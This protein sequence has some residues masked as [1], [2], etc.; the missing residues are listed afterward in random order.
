MVDFEFQE[1]G[2]DIHSESYQLLIENAKTLEGVIVNQGYEYLYGLKILRDMIASVVLEQFESSVFDQMLTA[3]S[4]SG[5]VPA[6]LSMVIKKVLIA[7][8]HPTM[9]NN[10]NLDGFGILAGLN[11]EYFILSDL[12]TIK[13]VKQVFDASIPDK[14][15]IKMEESLQAAG[16][17]LINGLKISRFA[18]F[19]NREIMDICRL[20]DTQLVSLVEQFDLQ[21][22]ETKIQKWKRDGLI[23]PDEQVLLTTESENRSNNGGNH[24]GG[25]RSK[26]NSKCRYC[27]KKGHYQRD[28]PK[29]RSDHPIEEV[30]L[31]EFNAS[32][33][34]TSCSARPPFI[35][36]SAAT[37]HV[38]SSNHQLQNLRPTK[39][40]IKGFTGQTD[41]TQ[42]G[43]L[44]LTDHVVLKGVKVVP[45]AAYNVISVGTLAS[46]DLITTFK[47]E[48]GTITKEDGSL[49]AKIVRNNKFW[50]LDEVV[51]QE[52]DAVT[53]ER[54][55]VMSEEKLKEAKVKAHLLHT[56]WGHC[57]GAQLFHLA[58]KQQLSL[59]SA[60][61]QAVIS[62]CLGCKSLVKRPP[63][64]QVDRHYEVGELIQGDL[65]G[66]IFEKYILL[67]S[68]RASKVL[69][70]KIL[71]TKREVSAEFI[72]LVTW[73]QQRIANYH[74]KKVLSIRVD[75]EFRT[76]KMMEFAKRNGIDVQF[77][78]AYASYQNG[79]SERNNR[80][81][82][83]RTR[84]LLD[85]PQVPREYYEYAVNHFIFL[86]NRIWNK[87]LN[88]SPI[89]VLESKVGTSDDKRIQIDGVFGC[90]GFIRPT[91]RNTKKFQLRDIPVIFL[92]YD[93][94]TAIG[95]FLNP[96]DGKI[97]RTD[98][99][100]LV[101]TVY[102]FKNQNPISIEQS[103]PGGGS[104]GH[105]SGSVSSGT[106][107]S[108][109]ADE[110]DDAMGEDIAESKE[111]DGIDDSSNETGSVSRME[112]P[113][114][115]L[116][117][118]SES[119]SETAANIDYPPQSKELMRL[120]NPV[121]V[122]SAHVG[123]QSGSMPPQSILAKPVDPIVSTPGAPRVIMPPVEPQL[124]VPEAYQVEPMYQDQWVT[125]YPGYNYQHDPIELLTVSQ[126][127]RP[128]SSLDPV[129]AI[130][131]KAATGGDDTNSRVR[132]L[133]TE[134]IQL[135]DTEQIS[136]L[137]MLIQQMN[138]DVDV[139]IPQSMAEALQGDES[140][141]WLVAR[142]EELGYMKT[143]DI[144]EEV[145]F[146]DDMDL[147][148]T[149][150]VLSIK[151]TLDGRVIK[152]VRLVARGFQERNLKGENFS[153]VVSLDTLRILLA[154]AAPN[155][156]VIQS[157]D[158]TRAFLQSS[159][160]HP[161]FLVPPEGADTQPGCVWKLNRAIY[162]L[163]TSPADWFNHIRT[164]LL[165]YSGQLQQSVIEQ[166]LFYNPHTK[167]YILLYVDD[168]LILSPN[169]EEVAKIKEYLH[170]EL[171]INE[172]DA[173][174]FIGMDLNYDRTQ[175]RLKLSLES[176]LTGLAAKEEFT[177]PARRFDTPMERGYLGNDL[178]SPLL[179]SGEITKYQQLI[180]VLNYVVNTVRVDVGYSVNYLCQF[181]K[182]PR[183]THWKA[184]Q[185]ILVYLIQHK[186][187]GITYG[188]VQEK[189]KYLK[190]IHQAGEQVAECDYNQ[191]IVIVS[192][193]SYANCPTTRKSTSGF[194]TLYKNQ[195]IDW[196]TGRQPIITLSSCESEYV[197][198]TIAAR[199]CL[200]FKHILMEILPQENCEISLAGD[201]QPGLLMAQNKSLSKLS[202]HIE[203]R[204]HF[205]RNLIDSKTIRLFYI[206][207]RHNLAD[208]LTK[209]LD[210]T[211]FKYLK[212]WLFAD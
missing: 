206:N 119:V 82:L 141:D 131:T 9:V 186:S 79:G 167:I 139:E 90:Q 132:Q 185:R 112:P 57:N 200:F 61:C 72:E 64:H 71:H 17:T 8:I 170:Q 2:G 5:R 80:Y 88:A 198:Y 14:E 45:D 107:S 33:N 168:V 113:S 178:N 184:A 30:N 95:L 156:W 69:K 116:M 54:V 35:I 40:I 48:G 158:A 169:N 196:K 56:Q 106:V 101:P 47:K 108:G 18:K 94:T 70:A 205:I 11:A 147:I 192:D 78:S 36:D 99:F 26:N 179:E 96:E 181:V 194:I 4:Y 140:V 111:G 28:C 189:V 135:V 1:G 27:D 49:I 160:S 44:Q 31:L 176:Y 46:Q 118:T 191:G 73:F 164:I 74:N 159:I 83:E 7:I 127:K 67:V 209:A 207:T 92:G 174:K 183:V 211:R 157:M 136:E 84:K 86:H 77:T 143:H 52:G 21:T 182:S 202:K 137:V 32:S 163:K 51:A 150:Y 201:N 145:P 153:P 89:Q 39:T 175:G 37:I 121:A 66:P 125:R 97:Q 85:T 109:L 24:N 22:I 129:T 165:S 190:R 16:I 126:E 68:D 110:Q 197:A 23:T 122:S 151:H 50:W 6:R 199:N 15:K 180:G 130:T 124:P 162:G 34:Y 142:G 91:I 42:E 29:Y 87:E 188:K 203:I 210:K 62:G 59:T 115:L 100:T 128:S 149:R 43:D 155:K 58:Q 172:R 102:P 65:I 53:Q 134:E 193:A 114:Q 171:D 187:D 75:N 13:L 204:Y 38:T 55:M 25:N 104:G 63:K 212:K 12:D 120:L 148:D 41:C 208:G 76:I 117:P 105:V 173:N 166:C 123:N 154:V 195:V 146:D 3:T 161:V 10:P 60:Q 152:K 93:N 20:E 144:Y 103:A 19:S 177:L 133:T 138:K 98:K 81:L